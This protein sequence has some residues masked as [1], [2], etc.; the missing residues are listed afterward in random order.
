MVRYLALAHNEKVGGVSKAKVMLNR[1]FGT[2]PATSTRV[3]CATC[4]W[5]RQIRSATCERCSMA[6]RLVDLLGGGTGTVRPGLQPLYDALIGHERPAT[7]LRWL[8]K[9]HVSADHAAF[10]AL[11]AG[12]ST[13]HL[14]AMLV[15]VGVLPQRDEH[16]ARL[17]RWITETISDHPETHLLHRYAVWHLLR[18]L[19]DRATKPLTAGQASVVRRNLSAAITLLGWMSARNL[20]WATAGQADLDQWL[21]RPTADRIAAGHFARWARRQKLTVLGYP[22]TG[23]DGPAGPM[24]TEARWEQARR[25]L[26]DDTLPNTEPPPIWRTPD[27]GGCHVR[28]SGGSEAGRPV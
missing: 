19:R 17:Q 18:R 12:K 21:A 11:P 1:S 20:T 27:V 22:S 10:D 7:L 26:L 4:G 8:A 28:K 14:R 2:S 5:S 25:L 15:A 16:L 6:A 3:D 24:D 23:W 13:E 9:A